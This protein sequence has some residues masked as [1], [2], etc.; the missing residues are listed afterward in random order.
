MP[1]DVDA[2]EMEA[3]AIHSRFKKLTPEE[4][5]K[6]AKEGRCF[7]CRKT[8]HM[9][10]NCPSRPKQNSQRRFQPKRRQ[11]RYMEEQEDEEEQEEE[12]NCVAHIQQMMMGLSVE[13]VEEVRAFSNSKNF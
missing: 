9:A 10:H 4:R 8:G 13:E 7:Y 11:V 3:D 1:M 2:A 12:K 6:L 5:S